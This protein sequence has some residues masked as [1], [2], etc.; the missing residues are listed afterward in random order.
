MLN[1]VYIYWD[2]KSWVDIILSSNLCHFSFTHAAKLK[3]DPLRNVTIVCNTVLSTGNFRNNFGL[4]IF[5]SYMLTLEANFQV[6]SNSATS[7][8]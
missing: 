7:Q 3:E 5:S 8:P 1:F 4:C 2:S 6:Q